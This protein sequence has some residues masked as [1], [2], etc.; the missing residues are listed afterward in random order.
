M[1]DNTLVSIGLVTWNSA[2]HLPTCL[3][4]IAAQTHSAC[5]LIVIDNASTDASLECLT[6]YSSTT[7]VIPNAT[8]LGFAHAHNQ[9]IGLSHGHYYLALNPDVVMQAGYISALVGALEQ[10]PECGMAG[11]KLL[12]DTEQIDTTGLFIDRRRRQYLRGHME[13]DRGQYDQP[14]EVF[15]IDGAAPLYRRAMID[16]IAQDGQFFDESFVTYKEDVDVAWRARLLGW[17]AWYTPAAQASHTRTFRPGQRQRGN[18]ETRRY[19]V[20]NRYLMLFKNETALGWQRD[21]LHILSYD[22]GILGYM[23]LLEQASLTALIDL[24]RLWP[25]VQRQRAQ[26]MRLK[27]VAPEAILKWFV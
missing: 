12:L 16:H 1:S 23:L 11:G 22:L 26:I 25:A 21:W 17:T 8:N 6:A 19:S 27:R 2:D 14:G 9:A 15:G 4:A 5:E 3:A 13:V 7:C 10:H 24:Y 18:P 20:R